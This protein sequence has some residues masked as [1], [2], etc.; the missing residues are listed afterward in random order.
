MQDIQMTDGVDTRWEDL[1]L[2]VRKEPVDGIT[3][4]II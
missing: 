3:L 1:L 2:F 4:Q